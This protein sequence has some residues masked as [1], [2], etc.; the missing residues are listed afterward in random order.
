MKLSVD[1]F[2]EKVRVCI[3]NGKTL[4]FKNLVPT[5]IEFQS[6][7]FCEDIAVNYFYQVEHK[8]LKEMQILQ[9]IDEFSN[10]TSK[11]CLA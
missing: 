11:I 4:N 8:F 2:F 10:E 6:V 7:F 5:L 3:K 9:N 1:K